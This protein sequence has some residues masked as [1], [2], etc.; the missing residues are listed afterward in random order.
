MQRVLGHLR[1]RVVLFYL[2]DVLIPGKNWNNL[3]G[4][5][6]L[7]L[8]AL[9][10]AGITVR[11]SKCEFLKRRVTYLGFEITNQGIEP[12]GRKLKAFEN[13]PRP[14]NTKSDDF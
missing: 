13:F 2:N 3:K 1:S 9:K 5:L 8:E 10:R 11:L 12:E 4:R 7:A 14:K 6:I